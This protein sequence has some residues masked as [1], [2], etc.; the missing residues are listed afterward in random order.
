MSDS[1]PLPTEAAA[2]ATMETPGP[3]NDD[4]RLLLVGAARA[5]G[6]TNRTRRAVPASWRAGHLSSSW[7]PGS[8]GDAL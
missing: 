2:A 4:R 8:W 3:A 1:T 5:P 7:Q 6:E